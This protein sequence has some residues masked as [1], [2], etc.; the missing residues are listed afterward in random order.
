ML[1]TT[2]GKFFLQIIRTWEQQK[3]LLLTSVSIRQAHRKSVL[4]VTIVILLD[5]GF[6]FQSSTMMY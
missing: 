4:L 5:K 3:S 1:S 2:P 6:K